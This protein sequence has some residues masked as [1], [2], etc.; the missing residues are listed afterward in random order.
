ML[1]KIIGLILTFLCGFI[2]FSSPKLTIVE[3]I[4][5]K[6]VVQMP[7]AWIEKRDEELDYWLKNQTKK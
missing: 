7:I 6:S 3:N 2:F 5:S 1:N 4:N